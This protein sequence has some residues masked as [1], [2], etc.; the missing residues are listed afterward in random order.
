MEIL[1]VR[2]LEWITFSFSR[3]FFQPR[4]WTQISPGIKPRSPAFQLDSLLAEPQGK[5]K[6][7]G[8]GSLFL[9]QT[10]FLTQESNH[11]LLHCRLILF[12]MSYQGSPILFF[13]FFIL[14]YVRLGVV[15]QVTWNSL[16]EET[17]IHIDT[18]SSVGI[19]TGTWAYIHPLP[20]LSLFLLWARSHSLVAG[21]ATIAKGWVIKCRM[22]IMDCVEYSVYVCGVR[23][24]Y[25]V[26]LI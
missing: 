3:G 19:Q 21:V 10:L 14:N 6:N 22:S 15:S 1:Q 8:V 25:S 17:G 24:S 26:S 9:F 2:I 4:D 18:H 20:I 5:S 11:G 12:Q 23:E 13:F 7:T 16:G